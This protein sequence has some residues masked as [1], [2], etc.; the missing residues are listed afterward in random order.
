MK[1]ITVEEHY[2]SKKANDRIKDLM[3]KKGKIDQ[4]M[5]NYVDYFMNNSL[6]SNLGD[7][8]IEIMDKERVDAQVVGYGNF[9]PSNVCGDESVELCQLVNDELYEATK[10][11]KGR[12]YAYAQ[13]PFDK[14]D[15]S[16]KELERCIKELKFVG[17]MFNGTLDGKF[18]DDER[19]FPIFKK[20]EEFD[21]PVYLHPGTVEKN[22]S[23]AYYAGKWG[24][25]V[26][27]TFAGYGI[28]WHYE[29][30]VH[31]IRMILSGIFDKLPNL[32]FVIGH[33]GELLPFY[34]DRLDMG[35]NL[36]TTGLKH[37]MS[38][39]LKNNFY[40]NPSGMFFK[41]DMDFCIKTMGV[42]HILWGEDFCYLSGIPNHIGQVSDFLNHYDIDKESKNKIAYKN[43][44]KLFKIG[45]EKYE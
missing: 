7:E 31:A 16:V 43:A 20:C 30:G 8:R 24:Q 17:V 32:K 29:V 9:P 28:G 37:E 1:I 38:Y 6:I 34:F 3:I 10:K 40:T 39:Y 25:G 12:F 18:L 36:K 21:V 42:D 35:L 45:E 2:M 15:E 33:W 19:F 5:I 44:E 4:N 14:V 27:M 41:D 13:L 11:Y 23:D 22:I 26:T